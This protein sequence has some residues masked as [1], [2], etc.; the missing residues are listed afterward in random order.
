MQ[1]AKHLTPFDFY[2][3]S[4]EE[5]PQQLKEAVGYEVKPQDIWSINITPFE[6]SRLHVTLTIIYWSE[7]KALKKSE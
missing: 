4:F 7:E 3:D 1:P 6:L 2:C 5:L